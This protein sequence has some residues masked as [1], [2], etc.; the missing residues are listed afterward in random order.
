M[1]RRG[2]R[3]LSEPVDIAAPCRTSLALHPYRPLLASRPGF[4]ELR[5]ERTVLA[6]AVRWHLEDRILVHGS[7]TVVFG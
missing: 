2:A 4:V 6:R 1:I 7:R 3:R 5:T